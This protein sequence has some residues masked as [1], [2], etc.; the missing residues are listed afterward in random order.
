MVEAMR[1]RGIRESLVVRVE[2]VLEENKSKIRVRG[3]LSRSFWTARGVRQR[4]PLS[5]LFFNILLV[6]MKKEMRKV[7]LGGEE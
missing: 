3:E 2:K 7:K 5:P 1:E 6:D 4:C